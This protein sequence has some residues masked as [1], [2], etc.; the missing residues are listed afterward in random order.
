MPEYITLAL[1]SDPYHAVTLTTLTPNILWHFTLTP[2]TLTP[3]L[4]YILRFDLQLGGLFWWEPE[5]TQFW[6]MFAEEKLEDRI[7]LLG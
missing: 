4:E 6:C 5:V 7:V 2:T 3:T 1:Y